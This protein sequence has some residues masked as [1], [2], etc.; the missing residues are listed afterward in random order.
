MYTRFAFEF[1]RRHCPPHRALS[2]DYSLVEPSLTI[3]GMIPL[4][5]VSGLGQ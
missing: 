2:N 3:D 4:I 5:D 1:S